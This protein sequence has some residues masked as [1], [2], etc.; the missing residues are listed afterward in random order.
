MKRMT[1]KK[2][3]ATLI[4]CLSFSSSSSFAAKKNEKNKNEKASSG[5]FEIL[6]QAYGN[7]MTVK[8]DF[9]QK[10]KNMIMGGVKE[11]SGV[12]EIKRPDKFRWETLAPEKSVL[13]ADGKSVM[14]YTPPFR[15]GEKGQL[16]TRKA[17]DVQSKT[18]IDLLS[19]QGDLKKTFRAI[20]IKENH[21]E[22]KPLKPAGDI[23]RIE[24]F[25]NNQTKLVDQLLLIHTTGNE[26]E[27]VLKNVNLGISVD[28][29]RFAFKAPPG[30]T[31]IRN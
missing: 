8:T 18:A 7:K 28:D 1:G 2:I 25:L 22:L 19:G 11:S 21:Y 26:T 31:E 20:R 5:L 4:L 3:V 27:L 16:L 17:A 6:K 15:E 24:L 13:I 29:S 14:Y 10:Q 12:I 9:V 23:E 30:T